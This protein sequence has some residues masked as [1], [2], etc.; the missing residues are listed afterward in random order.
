MKKLYFLPLLICIFTV[1]VFGQLNIPPESQRSAITQGIGDAVV[2]VVY[3]RPNIKGRPVWGGLVPLGKVWRTG[4]NENTTFEV[5][6]DVT[7]NGKPLPAGKYGLH[8][9][10]S[11]NEWIIIFSKVNSDWGSFT[12]DEKND[13]LRVTAKPQAT[14]FHET[15]AIEFENISQTAGD[16]AII[17]E[18]VKVPFTIDVGDLNK[19]LVNNFRSKMVGDPLTAANYVLSSKITTSYEEA[20]TWV[21]NSIAARQTFANLSLKAR[22]LAELNRKDEAIATAEKAI[23]QGKAAT[24]AANTAAL[25]ALLTEW[26]TKK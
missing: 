7:I 3:H 11:Q 16:A 17:W 13:A 10:P 23:Q 25:E 21:N 14:E 20:L 8:T 19:R 5:T 24:P 6:R 26:K 2:S 1:G 22:L 12:Y 15:M 4:A 18:K 9:I